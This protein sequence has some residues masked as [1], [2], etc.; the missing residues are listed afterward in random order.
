VASAREEAHRGVCDGGEGACGRNDGARAGET[1]RLLLRPF[2]HSMTTAN[3]VD[4][5][6]RVAP[7]DQATSGQPR[8]LSPARRSVPLALQARSWPGSE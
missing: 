7:A 8:P 2:C 1:I 5:S 4:R 3:W 6:R